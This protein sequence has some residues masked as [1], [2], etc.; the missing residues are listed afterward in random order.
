MRNY[1]PANHACSIGWRIRAT[2]PAA[3]V[4]P[5]THSFAQRRWFQSNASMRSCTRTCCAQPSNPLATTRARVHQGPLAGVVGFFFLLVS[6]ATAQ[7]SSTTAAACWNQLV[8]TIVNYLIDFV[9]I[10]YVGLPSLSRS[11]WR[12]GFKRQRLDLI[13]V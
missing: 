7:N 8:R 1:L 13:F 3:I 2:N 4:I 11:I 6:L 9:V 12:G 10:A 5:N